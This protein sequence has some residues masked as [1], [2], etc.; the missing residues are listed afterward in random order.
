VPSLG[1]LVSTELLSPYK[2][3]I[4]QIRLSVDTVLGYYCREP[5]GLVKAQGHFDKVG[6]LPQLS[7]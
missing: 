1:I 2:V 7:R 3:R 5:H 4:D 6:L